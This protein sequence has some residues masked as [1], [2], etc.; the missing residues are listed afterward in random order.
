[1][2]ELDAVA[3]E[4]RQGR[5]DRAT[6]AISSAEIEALLPSGQP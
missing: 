5:L 1:M 2:T 3:A 4:M 6:Q